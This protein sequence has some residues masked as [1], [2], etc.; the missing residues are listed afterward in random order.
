MGP[1]ELRAGLRGQG[2]REKC[3]GNT[4]KGKLEREL[5]RGERGNAQIQKH[6]WLAR[7]WRPF[8]LD[9]PLPEPASDC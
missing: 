8:H 5:R 3:S 7:S 6:Q 1:L 4:W 9:P 2:R